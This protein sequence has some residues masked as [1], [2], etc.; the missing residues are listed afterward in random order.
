MFTGALWVQHA[1][2]GV[3][4]RTGQRAAAAPRSAG[5]AVATA[6]GAGSTHDRVPVDVDRR[7]RCR[8]SASGSKRSDARV[9]D[10][11]RPCRRDRRARRI[12]DLA[13]AHPR[14]GMGRAAR[15]QHHRRDGAGRPAARAHLLA[16]T[17]L[18]ADRVPGRADDDTAASGI[19]SAVIASGRTRLTVLGM[20]PAEIDAIEQTRRAAA[21]RHRGRAAGAASS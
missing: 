20:T 11:D 1:R 2:G 17:A 8:S 3:A 13:R 18:V 21:A 12:A 16:G 9:A 5:P 19:A 10:A 4:V 7:R 6:A 15:R 14:G